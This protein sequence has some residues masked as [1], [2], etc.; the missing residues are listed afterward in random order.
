MILEFVPDVG[1]ARLVLAE[2]SV[3]AEAVEKEPIALG[4]KLLHSPL[5]AIAEEGTRDG[6]LRIHGV[7]DGHAFHFEGVVII[8]YVVLGLIRA[9]ERE[10]QRADSQP[11]RLQD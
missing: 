11:S 9:H 3:V 8:L 6:D 2:E 7:A 4:T 10:G 5:V 1:L